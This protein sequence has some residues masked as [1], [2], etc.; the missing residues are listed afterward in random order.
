MA[1]IVSVVLAAGQSSRFWPLGQDK[2]K[3]FYR[4]GHGQTIVEHTVEE[5]LVFTDKVILV[6]SLRDLG[7]ARRLFENFDFDKVQV[8]S[9]QDN[10][11]GEGGALLSIRNLI[12]DNEGIFIT[13][14]EK[15]N[16]KEILDLFSHCREEMIA[17]RKTS[18]PDLYGMVALDENKRITSIIE[19]PQ[20]YSGKER[21]RIVSAYLLRP[22]IF[23]YIEKYGEGHYNF[24]IALDKYVREHEV[25]GVSVDELEEISLKFPWH[26]LTINKF[27][28][29]QRLN[30]V[31][32]FRAEYISSASVISGPVFIDEGTKI[33]DFVKIQG[34]VYIGK[35]VIIGDYSSV[36]GCS[37]IDDDV[38]IG[39]HCE[40]KNSIILKGTHTHRNFIGDS[41]FDENCRVGAGTI[42]A[43][44]RN[45][46]KEILGKVRGEKISTGLM[47]LGCI[48]GKSVK[49]G[50]N[51]SIMP[52]V[53]IGAGV[54]IWPHLCVYKDLPNDFEYKGGEINV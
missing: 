9:Q 39:S 45:D 40:I 12:K 31:N 23:E 38:I 15:V 30:V 24:E 16:I 52:G 19:K 46:R 25:F 28:Q 17:V 32:S 6:V 53:K 10:F 21:M 3:A 27:L 26:L 51:C 5:L 37:F 49:L 18:R 44:R 8:V 29:K 13:T 42:T 14:P 2:H 11:D 36:R 41:I 43:N 22:K 7:Y 4:C 50:I 20:I 35:N 33:M 1:R 34:P 47:S 54:N 48:A